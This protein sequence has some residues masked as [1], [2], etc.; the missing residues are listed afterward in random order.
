[1]VLKEG[2]LVVTKPNGILQ[3]IFVSA[4][5]NQA[6][7]YPLPQDEKEALQFILE[8]AA[9]AACEVISGET[10]HHIVPKK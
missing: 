4:E 8:E 10:I 6:T 9:A 2:F 1:M 3:A 7:P 5:N